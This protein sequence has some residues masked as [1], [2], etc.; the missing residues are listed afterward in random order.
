MD[1]WMNGWIGMWMDGWMDG[2]L[3]VKGVF[4]PAVPQTFSLTCQMMWVNLM[5]SKSLHAL[6]FYVCM[7]S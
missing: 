3:E 1:K 6:S 4:T 7:V 2:L 5:F